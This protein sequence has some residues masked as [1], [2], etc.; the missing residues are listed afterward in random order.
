MALENKTPPKKGLW[1]LWFFFNHLSA[2]CWKHKLNQASLD[3]LPK[4]TLYILELQ[5]QKNFWTP[6]SEEY[7]TTFW[8]LL[9]LRKKISR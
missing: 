1:G 9:C 3:L 7:L 2:N 5:N 4:I 6:E 8:D